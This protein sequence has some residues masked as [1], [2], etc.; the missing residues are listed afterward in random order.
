MAHATASDVSAGWPFVESHGRRQ[1]YARPVIKN[2]SNRFFY[3]KFNIQYLKK[4]C[5]Y[6]YIYIHGGE[7]TVRYMV[8]WD[9]LG[10]L[11]LD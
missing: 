3:L 2:I 1:L 5:A 7:R 6:I 11:L 9:L 4:K 8:E 10:P